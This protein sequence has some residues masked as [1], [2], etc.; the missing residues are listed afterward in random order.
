MS[1]KKSF[2]ADL[3][4]Q[5]N[6]YTPGSKPIILEGKSQSYLRGIVSSFNTNNGR[7][8]SVVQHLDCLLVGLMP[9]VKNYMR[10]PLPGQQPVALP[11][12]ELSA[13]Q[14]LQRAVELMRAVRVSREEMHEALNQYITSEDDYII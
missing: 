10:Q 12:V 8:F 13:A 11:V 4:A 2:R 6:A 7:Q 9:D 14:H 5:L 1:K 3:A